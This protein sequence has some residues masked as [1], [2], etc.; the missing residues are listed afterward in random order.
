MDAPA[1]QHEK[2]CRHEQQQQRADWSDQVRLERNQRETCSR[3]DFRILLGETSRE[4]LQF[5]VCSFQSD[6]RLQAA[7]DV[8]SHRDLAIT[9]AGY[10]PQ[11]DRDIHVAT[12][13]VSGVVLK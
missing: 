10:V 1:E 12:M 7:D 11:A 8:H 4:C 6:A 2:P 9:E 5:A 3:V 13:K